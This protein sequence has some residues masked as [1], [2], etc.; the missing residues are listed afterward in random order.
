MALLREMFGPG[1]E[2]V[3]LEHRSLKTPSNRTVDVA[4]IGSNYHI[5]CNPSDAGNNDRFVV[6]EVIKEVASHGV[7]YSGNGGGDGPSGAS[8]RSFKVVVLTE[9]DRLSRQAQAS[10]RRTMEKYSS[11]CR[12]VLLCESPSKI[13]DPVRS[14]CLGVRVPAPS[15]DEVAA[16]LAEVARRELPAPGCP[17]D[18]ALRISA[19]SG[20]N[21]RRALL[22]LESCAVQQSPL[23]AD[24]PVALPDWELYICRLAREILQDQSPAKLLQARDMIYELLTNCIPADVIIRTLT[25][26]LCKSLDDGTKHELVH[27]AAHYEHRAQLGSKDVF[28]LEAFVAKFMAI[29]KRWL[30]QLF[31]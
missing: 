26:E 28:H 8:A 2:R 6:Q 3:R 5:E 22:M 14:R 30:I 11:V 19:A 21:L 12:I 4:T 27:W 16:V 13:I 18:L 24:Q 1:V 31:A 23:S 15:H 10:L 17:R 25:R 20:Q 9:A 7:L 29:Y